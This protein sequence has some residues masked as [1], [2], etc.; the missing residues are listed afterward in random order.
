MPLRHA[1]SRQAG[2]TPPMIRR[3]H[4]RRALKYFITLRRVYF[5]L[6]SLTAFADAESPFRCRRLLSAFA[7][8]S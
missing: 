4:F 1:I 5:S 2:H 6:F 7:T 3:R 8:F